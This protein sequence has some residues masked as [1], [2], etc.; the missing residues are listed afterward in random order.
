VTVCRLVYC[1]VTIREPTIHIFI[2]M[3]TSRVTVWRAFPFN[4]RFARVLWPYD[5]NESRG[6]WSFFFLSTPALSACS[7]KRIWLFWKWSHLWQYHT[8]PSPHA[9]LSLL[10]PEGQT[11][12]VILSVWVVPFLLW[13]PLNHYHRA[14]WCHPVYPAISTN[15][16]AGWRCSVRW[17]LVLRRVRCGRFC[18]WVDCVT[19]VG[20]EKRKW[21]LS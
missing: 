6:K 14:V 16:A 21:H 15:M 17:T 7:L 3:K 18:A 12:D 13:W 10:W 20:G 9:L 4:F 8:C 11:C 5:L 19:C 2:A 1:S